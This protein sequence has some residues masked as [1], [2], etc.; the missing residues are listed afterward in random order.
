MIKIKKGLDLPITGEPEQVIHDAAKVRS[1]ALIG[2]DYVGLKPTMAVKVGDRVKL[3]QVIFTD[4]KTEGVQYTSPGA[5]VVK[6]INRG[7]RRVL[8]S[9]VIELDEQ[10]E[11]VEFARYEA[12]QLGSLS[13]E[14]VQDNLIKS[15]LWTAFRTRLIAKYRSWAPFPI[16]F[17]SQQLIPTPWL[18]AQK[19]FWLVRKLCFSK[20]LNC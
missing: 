19:L 2:Y 8:Q 1:V 12:S 11:S 5:G 7:D 13:R 3:G 10:E 15:G 16:L 17:L 20:V 4:K 18:Q 9:V 6:E 14:Q